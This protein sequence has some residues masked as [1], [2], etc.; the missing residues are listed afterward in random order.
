VIWLAHPLLGMAAAG[1][2]LV[3]G[4]VFF[5]AL[6]IGSEPLLAAFARATLLR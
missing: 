5:V 2:A 4:A 1:A 3:I 6:G